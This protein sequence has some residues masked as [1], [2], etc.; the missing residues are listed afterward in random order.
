MKASGHSP[1]QWQAWPVR[2]VEGIKGLQVDVRS[3]SLLES[4][5]RLSCNSLLRLTS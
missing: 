5:I 2:H 1:L 3:I 4:L